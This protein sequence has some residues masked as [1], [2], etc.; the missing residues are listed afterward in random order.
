MQF[1]LSRLHLLIITSGIILAAGVIFF[2]PS[3]LNWVTELG[4][5]LVFQ[6]VRPYYT[7]ANDYTTALVLAVALGMSIVVWPV[8]RKD[9]YHLFWAWIFKCFVALFLLLFLED[10]YPSDSF[11]FWWGPQNPVFQDWVE[12]QGLLFGID[13]GTVGTDNTMLLV[14]HYNKLVPDF[15]VFSYHSTKLLFSMMAFIAIYIFY[16]AS[17][18]FTRRENIYFFWFLVLFPSLFIWTSRISK[19]SMILFTISLYICGI[20]NWNHKKQVRYLIL[21]V[22]GFILTMHLRP[23]M[24]MV[25]VGPLIF[26]VFYSLKGVARI[27][28]LLLTFVVAGLSI[29]FIAERLFLHNVADLIKVMEENTTNK[30]LGGSALTKAPELKGIKDVVVFTPLGMFT[31]LFRPLPGD[32]ST[33]TGLLAS[34]EGLLLLFLFLKAFVR[35]KIVELKEPLVIMVVFIILAWAFVYGFSS[36]NFG[37]IVRWKTQILPLYL[38]ITLYLG[39]PRP[40]PSLDKLSSNPTAFGN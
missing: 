17:V 12:Y 31:A 6:T 2:L 37:T 9:R 36:Q 7:V 35:T 30:S 33:P 22:I 39:R 23:W 20:V 13:V 32:I 40:R 28:F 38:G 4:H 16:R 15:M 25:L 29:N 11:G 8:R 10:H 3:Y 19:D 24:G 18:V 34:F 1:P 14:Y 5:R 27:F 26:Y 21:M